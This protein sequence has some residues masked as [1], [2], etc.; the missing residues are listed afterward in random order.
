VNEVHSAL[1]SSWLMVTLY[2]VE[3]PLQS[4]STLLNLAL[5][6]KLSR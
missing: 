6:N 2:S 3:Y 4:N 5:G 1:S